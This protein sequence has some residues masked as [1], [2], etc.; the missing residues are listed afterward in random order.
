MNE[1]LKLRN[2]YEKSKYRDIIHN[3]SGVYIPLDVKWKNIGISVSG[4][5]DSA[6]L[7]F[8]LLNLINEK[9]LD[10]QVHIISNIRMWKT[11][12]WQ[13]YNSLDVYHY[14]LNKFPKVKIKRHENFISPLLE[15]GNT[16]PNILDENKNLKSGDILQIQSFAE[17][18]GHIE[19]L[20]AYYNAVSKNPSSINIDNS[21]SMRDLEYTNDSDFQL[22]IK[23]HMLGVSCHPFRFIEK[24]W[25]VARYKEFDIMDLFNITRSCE[26]DTIDY[27]EIFKGLNYT[28]YI[29][30]TKIPTCGKCFWC[31]ERQWAIDVA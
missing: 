27:P 31:Q 8:L 24:N 30:N 5:A 6:L 15:W 14:L 23:D 25:I 28:N 3:I 19:N 1:F 9:N 22:M 2:A 7:S 12:P 20:N 11:R 10:T 4:G 21:M 16:G 18:I 13:K 29:P 26:G 17:Y